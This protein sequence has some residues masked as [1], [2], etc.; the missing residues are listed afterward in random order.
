MKEIWIPIK[1]FK[2]L[3]EVSNLG[4][5]RS[6]EKIVEYSDGRGTVQ[7]ADIPRRSSAHET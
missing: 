5:I 2:G 1:E 4:R 3:Y 6:I 7:G